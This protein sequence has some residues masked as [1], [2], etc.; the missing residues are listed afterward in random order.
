MLADLQH[1]LVHRR[2]RLEVAK[3]ADSEDQQS[4]EDFSF[5]CRRCVAKYTGSK[6][7]EL[8]RLGCRDSGDER[9]LGTRWFGVEGLWRV[10]VSDSMA[11]CCDSLMACNRFGL[12]RYGLW[13]LVYRGVSET[14]RLHPHWTTPTVGADMGVLKLKPRFDLCA[15]RLIILRALP[16]T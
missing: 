1:R 14:E 7:E 4:L 8:L 2:R 9:A 5:C 13:V 10:A 3:C 16:K 11:S 6:W 15:L 12:L